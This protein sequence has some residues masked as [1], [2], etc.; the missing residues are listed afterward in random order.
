MIR[1]AF[2]R[3]TARARP[4]ENA[5]PADTLRETRLFRKAEMNSEKIAPLAGPL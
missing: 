3:T 2:A 5:Q 1:N 4:H